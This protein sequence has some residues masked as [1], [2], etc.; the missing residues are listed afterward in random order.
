MYPLL[1]F[2]RKYLQTVRTINKLALP[3]WLS[4]ATAAMRR[5]NGVSASGRSGQGRHW[6]HKR[7]PGAGPALW[8][9]DV[10]AGQ[11]D[12]HRVHAADLTGSIAGP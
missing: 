5:V 11:R 1:T 4:T 3:D 2:P 8:G 6:W 12:R 9:A 10:L 7:V